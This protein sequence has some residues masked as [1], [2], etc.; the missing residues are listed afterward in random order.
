[1]YKKLVKRFSANP[2][3]WSRAA[4]YYFKKGDTDEAR[5][6]LPRSLKSLDKSKRESTSLISPTWGK[7]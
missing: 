7:Y 6:L 3:S 5:D 4:E 1:V 2:D